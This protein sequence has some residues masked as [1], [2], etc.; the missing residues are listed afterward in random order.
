MTARRWSRPRIAR[1]ILRIVKVCSGRRAVPLAVVQAIRA[2]GSGTSPL[3]PVSRPADASSLRSASLGRL[4]EG[5]EL[6]TWALG[7]RSIDELVEIVQR[8]RPDAIIEFGSGSSTVVLAWAIREV[9]GPNASP[10]IVSIEQDLE[11]MG[12]TRM[13]LDRAGLGA[14]AV[15]LVAPLAEQVIEGRRTICYAL[16]EGFGDALHGRLADLIVIDGPAGVPGVRFG[17]LPLARPHARDGA[18]FVLDDALRDGE[19]QVARL[20]A[21]LPYVRVEGIRLIEKGLL[22]GTVAAG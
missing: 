9:W 20:W 6:G 13:L 16:P 11:Q 12:R 2:I 14:E 17:T 21:A 22:V 15:V 19:L 1:R 3:A 18:R 8:V 5:V 10:R 4:L 7:P